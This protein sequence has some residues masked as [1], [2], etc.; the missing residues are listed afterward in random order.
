MIITDSDENQFETNSISEDGSSCT[1]ST[2][3]SMT[4]INSNKNYFHLS[5]EEEDEDEDDWKPK[6][7]K[8][9]TIKKNNK[10]KPKDLVVVVSPRNSPVNLENCILPFN[11]IRLGFFLKTI[12]DILLICI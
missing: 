6:K 7:R 2:T 1:D 10:R 12:L 8:R 5:D 9:K 11:Q 4:L 3:S